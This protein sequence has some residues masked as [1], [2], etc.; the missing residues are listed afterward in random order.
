MDQG[1]ARELEASRFLS[2]RER[3]LKEQMAFFVGP[4]IGLESDEVCA[5]VCGVQPRR[6]WADVDL[7]EFFLSLPAEIKFPDHKRKTLVRT[8]LR[9]TV[10][11]AI[12]DRRD[13]V[14][15]TDFV[16]D[17]V[18][19]PELRRWIV[20]PIDR[21]HGV[22]Y[23]LLAERLEK[24]SFGYGELKWAIDLAKVQAFLALWG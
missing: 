4:G 12:L 2:P 3:W 6:P 18:D 8:H 1:I 11:D 5:A 17:S 24:E 15:F 22:N 14:V 23:S 10:P 21:I 20:D 19:Y 13:H 7:C 16:L 9:G